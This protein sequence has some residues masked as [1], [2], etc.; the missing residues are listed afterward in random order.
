M[1]FRGVDFR[2]FSRLLVCLDA[3]LTDVLE[4][5]EQPSLMDARL[6]IAGEFALQKAALINRAWQEL[7]SHHYPALV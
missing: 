6:I 2:A 3:K 7:S 1:L 5:Y 4:V